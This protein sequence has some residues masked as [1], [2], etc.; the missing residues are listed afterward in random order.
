MLYDLDHVQLK[1][2][3]NGGF[4]VSKQHPGVDWAGKE[5]EQG[6]ERMDG[7]MDYRTLNY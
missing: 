4:R 5:G 7:R 2:G 6:G 1:V 3:I